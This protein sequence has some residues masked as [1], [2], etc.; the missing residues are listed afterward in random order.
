MP[1]LSVG[2]SVRALHWTPFAVAAG[3]G[4]VV[5]AAR[6]AHDAAAPLQLT[7][8]LFATAAGFALDDEAADVLGPS[9]TSLLRR[10]LQRVAVLGVPTVGAWA[11]LVI[12]QGTAGKDE[13]IALVTLFAGLLGVALAIAGITARRTGGRHAGTAV[14]AGLFTAVVVSSMLPPRWR[15]MPLGDIPGGWR[16]IYVRWTL[17]AVVGA[18][19]FLWS[20]RDPAKRSGGQSRPLT[21]RGTWTRRFPSPL[22]PRT[23]R[24]ES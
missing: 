4:A 9:P 14:G 6:H 24:R 21:R 18:A 1:L 5:V 19:V 10:R 20:S 23:R 17:C 13:S 11:V 16:S 8:M 12:V 15:P 22:L 2:H 3:L 7:S